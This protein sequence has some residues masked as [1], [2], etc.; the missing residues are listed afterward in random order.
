[1]IDNGRE[2]LQAL[3]R[4]EAE[5]IV[6]KA[7]T[8]LDFSYG[9]ESLLGKANRRNIHLEV[10]LQPFER[11]YIDHHRFERAWINLTSNALE[12]ANTWVRVQAEKKF[13]DLIVRVVDD[14][15]GVPTDFIPRL[16]QR[17][18]SHGKMDGTG[19]GLEYVKQIIRGH[20]GDV[21]YY[22]EDNQTVFECFIPNTFESNPMAAKV[23]STV[24][25]E[26]KEPLRRDIGIVFRSPL[27]CSD[28]LDRLS[29][30]EARSILWHQGF[31]QGYD[32]IITDDP[33]IVEKCID[34]GISVAE[35][36][37]DTPANKIVKK[38]LIRLGIHQS[39]M[40]RDA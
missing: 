18:A 30:V 27:L 13:D 8:S 34:E 5:N 11:I 21:R 20:G 4:G 9:Y 2:T 32:F 15:P 40:I 29:R 39:E 7:W 12:F 3:R 22:R 1:M 25:P 38:T 16:F 6:L 26:S 35:F 28:I 10:P 17:G 37:P 14:G 24:K 23:Q 19:L 36:S 31:N 33:S